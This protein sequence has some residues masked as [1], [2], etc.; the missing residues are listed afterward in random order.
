MPPAQPS[1]PPE[2][3]A[4]DPDVDVRVSGQRREATVH[5]WVVPVIAVGGMAGAA[6][7]HAL[8]LLWPTS[9]GGFPWATFATNVAG[10][11]LIGI[12]MVHVVETGRPHP[13]VRPFLGVGV[14]GGLPR[15]PPTPSRAPACSRGSSRG[16]RWCTC[17]GLSRRPWRR[18]LL[19]SSPHVRYCVSGF[20]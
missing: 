15:S 12:L 18:S 8:E 14:L 13:L 20:G 4:V 16:W 10:C 9:T 17:S 5:R 11:L 3:E 19:A 6:A 7:R 1:S 2:A